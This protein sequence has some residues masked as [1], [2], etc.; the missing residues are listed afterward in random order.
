MSRRGVTEGQA[1]IKKEVATGRPEAEQDDRA[2]RRS[3]AA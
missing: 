2:E 3:W 1:K